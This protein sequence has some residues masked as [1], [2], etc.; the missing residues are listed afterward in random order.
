MNNCPKCHQKL[1]LPR[2]DTLSGYDMYEYYCPNC[3]ELFYEKGSMAL[4]KALSDDKS[5]DSTFVQES[6]TVKTKHE[7]DRIYL[8]FSLE[9]IDKSDYPFL[10]LDYLLNLDLKTLKESHIYLFHLDV[11]M[12]SFQVDEKRNGIEKLVVYSTFSENFETKYWDKINTFENLKKLEIHLNYP[13]QVFLPQKSTKHIKIIDV[14]YNISVYDYDYFD[15]EEME[16]NLQ[17]TFTDIQTKLLVH[18][19]YVGVDYSC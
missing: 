8:D 1:N 10:V 3:K 18:L 7:K 2:K 16:K 17:T 15:G 9:N 4:W 12:L 11:R 6:K 19:S 5:S 14:H 13:Q